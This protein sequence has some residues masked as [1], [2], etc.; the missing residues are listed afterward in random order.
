M[1]GEQQ[2]IVNDPSNPGNE[3]VASFESSFAEA[4]DQTAGQVVTEVE[5]KPPVAD[6]NA[7][8]KTGEV[9]K[10]DETDYKA[11][12]EKELQRTKSWEG[13]L[14]ASEQRNKELATRLTEIETSSTQAKSVS[15]ESLVNVDDP[16]IK[17][18]IE[19]MGD[20]FI[21]PLDAYMKRQLKPII[22]ELIKPVMEKVPEIE[23]KVEAVDEK[24][25]ADHFNAILEAHSDVVDLVKKNPETNQSV[26]DEYIDGLPY[27]E[28]VKAQEIVLRGKTQDVIKFLT[29]FKEKTG[30]TTVVKPNVQENVQVQAVSKEKINAAT[31]VKGGSPVIPKTKAHA[32]DFLGAFN[33]AV[34]TN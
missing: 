5:K 22:E 16:L 33:E 6:P 14:S 29:E 2:V 1:E 30:R 7:E 24:N 8:I 10:P 3:N 32:E 34:A 15:E 17:G 19:E 4:T 11:L 9:V 13:R 12:Y 20:D 26:I 21:K 28:A 31:A 27:R 18:F 25:S 23:K